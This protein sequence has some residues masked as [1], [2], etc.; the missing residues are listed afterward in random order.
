MAALTMTVSANTAAAQDAFPDKY[1]RIIAPFPGFYENVA[2]ALGESFSEQTGKNALV[3]V[4]PGADGQIAARSIISEPADGYTVFLSGSGP[5]AANAAMY[6]NLGY[7]PVADFS[8]V[9]GVT[10][11]GLLIAVPADSPVNSIA[12]LIALAKKDPT[13]LT[14]AGTG[15][16]GQA[17]IELLKSLESINIRH[18]P[19]KSPPQG[20]IDLISG[21][22]DVMA[23]TLA[24]GV[25]LAKD[26]KIKILAITSAERSPLAPDV[27]T[28]QEA[29]V[30]DY[31]ITFWFGVWVRS[32]TPEPIIAKLNQMVNKAVDSPRMKTYLENAGM[33]AFSTT[34]EELG[35]F[36]K[37]EIVKWRGIVEA[38]GM[39]REQ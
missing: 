29:G 20:I 6:K 38:A 33:R 39:Q 24:D 16:S 35:E 31:E 18:I 19:Y 22:V 2:R 8:P 37:S 34:P 7:D 4:K 15:A 10:I 11:G 27:P 14:F 17:A 3:E 5:N 13:K 26:K 12:D 9:S 23:V 25:P 32:G 28:M 36:Q 1:I 30:K 21:R